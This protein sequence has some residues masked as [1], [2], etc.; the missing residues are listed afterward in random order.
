[1]TDYSKMKNSELEGLLK[2]RGLPHNGKKAE[3]VA[4]LQEADKTGEAPQTSDPP[5]TVSEPTIAAPEVSDSAKPEP[6]AVETAPD[7]PAT[8]AAPTGEAAA[9]QA[10]AKPAIDF[11]TGLAATSIDDEI[12]R[13]KKRAE[14]FGTTE[15]ETEAIKNLERA[16]K[17]GTGPAASSVGVNR[18][19]E[20]LPERAGRKR[21]RVPEP[22]DA[23]TGFD[24]PGLRRRGQGR[25]DFRG[26]GRGGARPAGRVE[27]PGSWMSAADKEAAEKRRKKFAA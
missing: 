17:F 8:Q 2:Q 11:S 20:A 13:R 7:A 24:D 26:R 21:G 25:R 23:P 22:S 3:M 19:D 6:A 9:P 4:R 1:M 15:A 18:L 10:E 16:K 12:A 27:K 5:A 14:K